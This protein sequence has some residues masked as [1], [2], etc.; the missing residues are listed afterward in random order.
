MKHTHAH[1]RADDRRNQRQRADGAWRLGATLVF[2]ASG[3]VELRLNPT[4]KSADRLTC[5]GICRAAQ[6]SVQILAPL[7]KFSSRQSPPLPAVAMSAD[8]LFVG[9]AWVARIDLRFPL[10]YSL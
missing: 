3:L 2:V 10:R 6:C 9:R 1:G 5:P 8:D 4:D 7:R